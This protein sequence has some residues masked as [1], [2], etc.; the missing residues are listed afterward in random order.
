[1]VLLSC[2]AA[3]PLLYVVWFWIGSGLVLVWFWID[4]GLVLVWFWFGYGLDLVWFWIGS[5]L[6]MN[7]F[8]FG[9]GF[10][11]DW[12]WLGS[13]FVLVWF[14]LC[15]GFGLECMMWLHHISLHSCI[16]ASKYVQT[17]YT[18]E[19]CPPYFGLDSNYLTWTQSPLIWTNAQTQ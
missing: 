2:S 6:V 4:S 10:V 15:S 8:W 9:S 3:V 7:L 16:D 19:K 14:W 1:M 5:G 13:G 11:L 12:F 18:L 17:Q